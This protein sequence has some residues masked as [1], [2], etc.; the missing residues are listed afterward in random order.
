MRHAPERRRCTRAP[1]G[2][3]PVTRHPLAQ[4]RAGPVDRMQRHRQRLSERRLV[5][6]DAVG[7][8]VALPVAR[9]PG[10][11]GRRPGCA[12]SAWRC[13]KSACS[14]TGSADPSGNTRSDG[15]VGS[16]RPPPGHPM[17]RPET[18]LTQGAGWCR[19]SHDRGS[20]ARAARI[21]AEAAMIV[22]V[23]IGAADA[24][25]LDGDLDLTRA[26]VPPARV[27]S[28]RRSLAA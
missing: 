19:P 27:S 18:P 8:L 10:S 16:A 13:H 11:G 6:R 9:P 24:A 23:Q 22:V 2:P 20:S 4:K 28:M 25:C 1:I 21:V 5:D 15:R 17:A 12:A 26:G 14:G 7:H 3:Q